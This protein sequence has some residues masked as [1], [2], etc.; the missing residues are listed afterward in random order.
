MMTSCIL[1]GRDSVVSR[2]LPVCLTCIRTH[3]GKALSIAE[4]AHRKVKKKYVMPET[5]PDHGVPCGFC[6]N[7]CRIEEGHSGYCGMRRNINGSIVP[8]SGSEDTAYLE[9]YYDPLPTNCVSMN[10]C[11]ER[12]TT[13]GKN[14]AVF[15]GGCTYDCLFCQNW[16]Y[17]TVSNK[18][19]ANELASRVDSETACICYFGGDP[20]PQILHA[21]EVARTVDVR[22]CWETNGAFSRNLA[23]RVGR[24]AFSSGGT[25][26]FD[27]KA[28]SDP[29]NCALCGTSNKNTFSN[30]KYIHEQ[31][32][33]KE[34]PLL[35]AS[36]LLVPGYIDEREVSDIAQFIAALDPDI[37]Y[38][39]LA[40]HPHFEFSDLP[41]TSRELAHACLE[42]ARNH[43]TRVD[44]GNVW[45]LT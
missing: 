33:R 10:Y 4:A 1:C 22:I 17:R 7:S 28:Y 25:V 9:W 32:P 44:L 34:P 15:Y 20:T 13:T 27:L 6:V 16:Q 26:K 38:S 41:F 19:S 18:M 30:F 37:P 11:G 36:T 45:L 39:L 40:F 14:L 43:L 5:P 21:L 12:H 2:A 42:A 31:F 23:K 24:T 29:L 35:V 8:R 3:P